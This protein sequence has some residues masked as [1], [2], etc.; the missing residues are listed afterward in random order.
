MKRARQLRAE[1]TDVELRL[2]RYP[3]RRQL[4]G[5]YFRK[6]CPI[7]PYIADFACLEAKLIIELDGSQHADSAT[8]PARDAWFA[9]HGYRTLRFWNNDVLQNTDGVIIMITA[10][11][12]QL[13]TPSNAQAH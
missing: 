10:A 1:M 3:R 7:G 12:G 9:A 5:A 4:N 8:D 11:L 2:W 6:Q 13:E